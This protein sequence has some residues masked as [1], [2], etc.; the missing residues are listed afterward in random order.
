MDT[1]FESA[2]DKAAKICLSSAVY[3]IQWNSNPTARTEI[4]LWEIFIFFT[5]VKQKGL[6]VYA[7]VFSLER[8]L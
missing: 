6:T 7:I 2:K 8:L 5:Q 4:R 1:F 3:K